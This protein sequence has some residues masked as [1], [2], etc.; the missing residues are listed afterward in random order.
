MDNPIYR[1]ALLHLVLLA[2][3]VLYVY[4]LLWR[5]AGS[6]LGWYLRKKTEGRRCHILELVE[7]DEKEYRENRSNRTR[8][9]GDN[10]EDGEWEKVDTYTT[11]T[12][13]NGDKGGSDDDW[14]GIVGFFHPFW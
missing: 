10:G 7:S 11:G 3:L 6:L 12:S 14:D 2:P 4:P 5:T 8:T 1:Y 13:K 9:S